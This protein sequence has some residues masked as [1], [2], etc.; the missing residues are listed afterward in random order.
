[1]SIANHIDGVAAFQVAFHA[2]KGYKTY[3][4][5]QQRG[6]EVA[7]N[8]CDISYRWAV[9]ALPNGRFAPLVI[10]NDNVPG[11]PGLFLGERNICITN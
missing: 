3:A 6:E 5:A 1:M 11:G 10:V 7:R 8:R 2:V 4:R 9:I